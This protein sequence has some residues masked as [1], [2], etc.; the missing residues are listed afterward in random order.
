MDDQTATQL[1]TGVYDLTA[2]VFSFSIKA[3]Y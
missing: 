1:N 2:N 3:N